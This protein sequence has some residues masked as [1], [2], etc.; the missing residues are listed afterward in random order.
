MRLHLL[1]RRHH[2]RRRF[3]L[4]IIII[5]I[6]FFFFFCFLFWGGKPWMFRA[7]APER[8]P[9]PLQ[10]P[11]AGSVRMAG[12]RLGMKEGGFRD[13][14]FG[15]EGFGGKRGVFVVSDR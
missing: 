10:G 8:I 7:V 5:I 12:D 11:D 9:G 3:L 4:F 2:L 14:P 13:L 1:R 6:I 15:A